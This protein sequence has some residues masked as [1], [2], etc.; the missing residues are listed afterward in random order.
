MKL[1]NRCLLMMWVLC[2][3]GA[4]QL[5]NVGSSFAAEKA[6]AKAA[7]ATASLYA[8]EPVPLTPVQCAQCHTP[9]YNNLK[10]DGGRHRFECQKCHQA[11]HSY[12]PVKNNWL[13]L[14]P[15]CRNCHLLPHGEKITD[16]TSCHSNPHAATKIPMSKNLLASCVICHSGPPEQLKKF[17]SKHTNLACD[18]CHTS[19]G[20]IPSCNACHKPHYE[21]QDFKTC[22]KCHPVHK[23]LQIMFTK[24]ADARTCS[25]C[26]QDVYTKWS[27]TP[28][29]HGKVNCA[30]CH[31]EHGFIPACS[32]CHNQPHSKQLHERFP[33]CL[34]CH[35]DPHD[36][37]VKQ[38]SN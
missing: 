17:P 20:F 34:T 6:A 35:Q 36:L 26:H 12:S 24:D 28:S 23:P 25:A 27:K 21:G 22:T 29:K 31:T 5:A 16:C 2:V 4:I 14:M 33:K 11:F 3:T 18:D 13:E 30:N 15:K 7:P 8:S 37:P 1:R 38:R 9:I 10:N 19:H 32:A